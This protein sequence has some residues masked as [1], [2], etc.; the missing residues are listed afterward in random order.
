VKK[1]LTLFFL[2]S[3]IASAYALRV[4]PQDGAPIEL[5]VEQI[6]STGFFLGLH[7]ELEEGGV[8][9][10][11]GAE[12][13]IV[14]LSYR[15]CIVQTFLDLLN[16]KNETVLAGILSDDLLDLIKFSSFLDLKDGEVKKLLLQRLLEIM[17]TIAWEVYMNFFAILVQFFGD[18]DFFPLILDELREYTQPSCVG[19]CGDDAISVAWSRDSK[20]VV[21]GSVE[22]S[23]FIVDAA[24][25]R[26]IRRVRCIGAP[27]FWD[28]KWFSD[29][30]MIVGTGFDAAIHVWGMERGTDELRLPSYNSSYDSSLVKWSP[31]EKKV[32]NV[33]RDGVLRIYDVETKITIVTQSLHLERIIQ[34][35]WSPDGTKIVT[36][37]K[38]EIKIWDSRIGECLQTLHNESDILCVDW[39]DF[40]ISVLGDGAVVQWDVELGCCEKIF[41]NSN[42]L[43]TVIRGSCDGRYF[44]ATDRSRSIYLFDRKRMCEI[45]VFQVDGDNISDIKWSPDGTRFAV[46]VGDNMQIWKVP[47]RLDS[48]QEFFIMRAQHGLDCSLLDTHDGIKDLY[49]SLPQELQEKFCKRSFF[50]RYCPIM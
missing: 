2:F 3:S 12:A 45:G 27:G 1:L 30:R 46:A 21:Y 41:Q 40:L 19:R 22:G 11:V 15:S 6:S 42:F 7:E 50:R 38:S 9:T 35:V 18:S 25:C 28:I 5:S 10:E 49:E 37:S 32:A 20:N 48:E 34:V 4:Q 47:P 24:T 29:E 39:S 16:Q 26:P 14:P 31:V 44:I 13:V 8:F 43:S 33:S 36:V 23:V 17:P